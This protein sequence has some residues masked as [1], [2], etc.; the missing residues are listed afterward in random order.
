MVPKKNA[1]GSKRGSGS[2][3]SWP[4]QMIIDGLNSLEAGLGRSLNIKEAVYWFS[5]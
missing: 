1:G 3:D 5:S 4:K 2:L